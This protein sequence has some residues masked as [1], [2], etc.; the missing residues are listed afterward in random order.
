MTWRCCFWCVVPKYSLRGGSSDFKSVCSISTSTVLLVLM[1][2][3][4]CKESWIHGI[5]PHKGKAATCYPWGSFFLKCSLCLD[6]AVRLWMITWCDNGCLAG[7]RGCIPHSGCPW[8]AQVKALCLLGNM[9]GWASHSPSGCSWVQLVP[10]L[11]AELWYIQLMCF[12]E[13]EQFTYVA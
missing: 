6:V 5:S 12:V 11:G 7:P 9:T 1:G 10:V 2:T 8:Q 3:A 4:R 13:D